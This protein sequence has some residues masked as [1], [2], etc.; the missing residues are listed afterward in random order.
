MLSPKCTEDSVQQSLIQ[1]DHAL[2]EANKCI[3]SII[4]FTIPLNR[5]VASMIIIYSRSFVMGFS[6][7]TI[8]IACYLSVVACGSQ[9]TYYICTCTVAVLFQEFVTKKALHAVVFTCILP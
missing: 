9:Y 8:S 4:C 6:L 5:E 3:V 2:L 1:L 7:H